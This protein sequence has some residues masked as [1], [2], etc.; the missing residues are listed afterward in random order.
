VLADP[1]LA[2]R[3][4]RSGSPLVLGPDGTSRDR[5][6]DPAFRVDDHPQDTRAR[7]ASE[8]VPERAARQLGDRGSLGR[9][10]PMMPSEAS[11]RPGRR[12]VLCYN[13]GSVGL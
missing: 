9:H 2:F 6:D 10:G 12:G 3:E 1:W 13:P 11:S 7:R 5:D 8:R 4:E